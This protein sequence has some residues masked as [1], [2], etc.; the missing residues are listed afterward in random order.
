[1]E[2]SV[3]QFDYVIVGAGPAGCV[4]ANRLSADPAVSVLLIEAGGKDTNP[5]IAMPRGFGQ[6]LGDPTFAWH[7]ATRPFGPTQQVESWVSMRL[8]AGRLNIIRAT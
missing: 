5:F 1:M 8:F 3:T 7:Y 6:L 4:L 2:V